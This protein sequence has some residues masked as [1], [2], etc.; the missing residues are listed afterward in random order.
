[1]GTEPDVFV[2]RTLTAG[3]PA[4]G[5][6]LAVKQPITAEQVRWLEIMRDHIAANPGI[7]PDEFNYAPFV[8][9]G[10]LASCNNSLAMS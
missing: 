1:M 4:C 8:Q 6:A 10:G 3:E 9:A 2:R 5:V 7:E